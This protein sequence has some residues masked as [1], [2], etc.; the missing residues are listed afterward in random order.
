MCLN[1]FESCL[2]RALNGSETV[3]DIFDTV[4]HVGCQAFAKCVYLLSR[5]CVRVFTNRMLVIVSE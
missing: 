5:F 2:K 3:W 4:S 1:V